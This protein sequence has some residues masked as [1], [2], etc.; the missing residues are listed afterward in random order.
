MGALSACSVQGVTFVGTDGAT[1]AD[2]NTD[3]DGVPGV[4]TIVSSDPAVTVTEGMTKT[5]TVSLSAEPPSDILINLAS[6]DDTKLGITPTSMLFK[7]T[8]WNNPKTVTLSGKSDPDIADES[9]AV[10]LSDGD[11]VLPSV[12]VDV[13]V[14]DDDGLAFQVTPTTLDVSEGATAPVAVH[15]TAQPLADVTVGVASTDT[16]TATVDRDTLT[17][18]TGNWN[19]DQTVTVSGAEDVDTTNDPATLRFTAT[20][21]TDA[22]TAI[23]V[24]D[25]DVLGI[26]L[27]TSSLT[28]NEGAS[29]SFSVSLTQQPSADVTITLMS[30]DTGAV[31]SGSGQL[32]FTAADWDQPQTVMLSAPQDVDTANESPSISLSAPSLTTRSLAV[33][34]VDD[35]VQVI[36]ATPSMAS[37]T[38]GT[39]GTFAAHLAFKPTADIT[40]SVASLNPVVASTTQATLTFTASNYAS[41]QT[42][43]ITAAQDPDAVN[44]ATTIR[45][46][47]LAAGLTTDVPLTVVDDDTLAIETSTAAVSL[48]EAGSTTFM[49]RL[50]AQPQGTVNVA[51]AST[52]PGAATV[53]GTLA[54]D[55]LNWAT[56]QSVTVTGVADADLASEAL[57]I[58]LTAAGVVPAAV[59]AAVTDDDMQQVLVSSATASVTE[60]Q[61][62]TVTATLK[63]QPG[64]PVSVDVSSDASLVAS[65]SP[66]TLSFSPSD[67]MMP[68]TVTISGVP[69]ADAVGGTA[70]IALALAGATPGAVAVTV[71]DDDVLGIEASVPSLSIGEAGSG[72]IGFRLTAAPTAAMTVTVTS[73]DAGAATASASLTFSAA[74]WNVYQN[75]T[76]AGVN[77]A[78]A[79]NESLNVTATSGALTK[80]VPVSVADDEVLGITTSVSAVTLTEAGTA[81]FTVQLSAAPASATTVSL[82]SPDVGA[83]TVSPA[84]YVFD[85]SNWNMPKTVTVTGVG[86]ADLAN[87][88]VQ[89]KAAAAGL[90]DRF[91]TATVNDDDTQIVLVT[92]GTA[93]LKENNE[94]TTV[95]VSLGFIPSGTVTVTV[96]SA[97]TSVVTA[98][99][100][101]L[102]FLPGNYSVAQPVT[103][104]SV[105]DVN[106]TTDIKDVTFT[107]PSA[108]AG[109]VTVTVTDVDV[110]GLETTAGNLALTEG[111]GTQTGSYGV[112]LTAQPSA[113]VDVL[114]TSPDPNAVAVTAPAT[115]KLTFTPANWNQFQSVNVAAVQ[116]LDA[117]NELVTVTTVLGSINKPVAVAVTDD[118][119]QG[120]VTDVGSVTLAEG[121]NGTFKVRLN[122]QPQLAIDGSDTS[123]VVMLSAA[124]ATTATIVT[125]ASQSLTFTSTNYATF[126][127][128]T[129]GG[130]E[131]NNLTTDAGT[132]QVTSG[133]LPGKTVAL[134]VTDNDTQQIIVSPT[135]RTLAETGVFNPTAVLAFDPGGT[136]TVNVVSTNTAAATVGTSTLT[137]DSSNYATPQAVAVTGVVDS[138]NTWTSTNIVF[139]AGSISTT[140]PVTVVEPDIISLS[141]PATGNSMCAGDEI[142]LDLKLTAAPPGSLTLTT[143]GTCANR[144]TI[145]PT[146]FT[147]TPTD[148]GIVQNISF[149][150][151]ISASIGSCTIKVDGPN[152]NIKSLTVNVLALTS[153]L[154]Q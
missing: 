9:V 40:V 137:F 105:H 114:I 52:D 139:S 145:S 111:A 43:T 80:V 122:A 116:D 37:V 18:T 23:T 86:D 97:D 11:S 21:I 108:T 16:A 1:S 129:V 113:N 75:V 27:S 152:M 149:V 48:G 4:V 36:V 6:A 84:S 124:P 100:G 112:R 33:S 95:N 41:D 154:C 89:I 148:Y 123:I 147:F 68:H 102:T 62:T 64:G 55:T 153:P 14:D 104:T 45:L 57:T 135:S 117:V 121:G 69:D 72:T 109:K 141:G 125:P 81:T 47:S 8:T 132:A 10:T 101:S 30:S 49:V 58:N 90:T 38:E 133:A 70:N 51:L 94:Q 66:A 26:A 67:Y 134:S 151:D 56:F 77:D 136:V 107:A 20:G 118:E 59:A 34:V 71:T 42:V 53:T 31:T 82:S 142:I 85:G 76:V 83:A 140:L 60:G 54:F 88:S 150:H 99:T 28:V 22:T 131:D 93:T 35:D 144:G 32:T 126:Q 5:F 103:L 127:T 17:F 92:P 44:G 115:G 50:T 13:T 24:T 7:P 78:D 110:L 61:N 15:L 138:N 143:S 46:E 29:A 87:E 3:P 25:N 2:G 79:M 119:T 91:V 12:T 73:S 130:K 65:A 96:A 128:V 98:S 146:S 74:N 39:S 63:F 106:T 120:I 19:V